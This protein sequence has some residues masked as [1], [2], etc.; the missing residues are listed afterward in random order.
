[1]VGVESQRAFKI[2]ADHLQEQ[3]RWG[4]LCYDH[5]LTELLW[6]SALAAPLQHNREC[7]SRRLLE[8]DLYLW[9]VSLYP[10]AIYSHYFLESI[11][12]FCFVSFSILL[13]QSN[14]RNQVQ[15]GIENVNLG[16]PVLFSQISRCCCHHPHLPTV[17]LY[18]IQGH[19]MSLLCGR[20][21][22]E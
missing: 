16:C 4:K 20:S 9:I 18:V 22:L 6:C 7:P 1:M 11:D 17:L 13:S 21:Y 3:F 15:E 2:S 10:L 19:L 12:G 8:I 14:V 5:G